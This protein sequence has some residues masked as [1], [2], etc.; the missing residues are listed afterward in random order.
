MRTIIPCGDPLEEVEAVFTVD[1]FDD[2]PDG[3][4]VPPRVD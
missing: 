4:P 2:A 1:A 3:A